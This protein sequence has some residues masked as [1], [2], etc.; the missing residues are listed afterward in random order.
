MEN[1]YI[2]TYTG[3]KFYFNNPTPDM[4]RLEDI[5]YSLSRLCR[6]TGHSYPFYSVAEH[7]MRVADLV[8]P[9]LELQ[10]LLHDAT[11][12]Y[13]GDMSSPL[14]SLCPGYRHVEAKVKYAIAKAFGI[15]PALDAEVKAADV[16]QLEWEMEHVLGNRLGLPFAAMS[17]DD[18]RH[19]FLLRYGRII[20]RQRAASQTIRGSTV[21]AA[22]PR[23]DHGNSA[24]EDV[25]QNG[26]LRGSGQQEF[27][28]DR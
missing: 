8:Q 5:A 3:L 28:F 20:Q 18:A 13:V 10:A 1:P 22:C 24:R 2:I 6:F 15:Y 26:L 21:S 12:A 25:R 23:E 14:K 11:E 9:K 16:D 27:P 17:M 19:A 4:V 7:S